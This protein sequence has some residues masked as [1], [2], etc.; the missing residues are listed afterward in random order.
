MKLAEECN[1][2]VGANDSELRGCARG[3]DASGVR[4]DFCPVLKAV[5]PRQDP[6]AECSFW[7]WSA[8]V[9]KSGLEIF[10]AEIYVFGLRTSRF[11]VLSTAMRNQKA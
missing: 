7:T 8:L 5:S 11:Y 1:P 6:V 3:G 10:L 4:G 9:R 2:K